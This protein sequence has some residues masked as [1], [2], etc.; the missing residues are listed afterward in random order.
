MNSS[1]QSMTLD[2]NENYEEVKRLLDNI[3]ANLEVLKKY[4]QDTSEQYKTFDLLRYEILSDKN[5][6]RLEKEGQLE[7]VI[8]RLHVFSDLMDSLTSDFV[9][10][11]EKLRE[12]YKDYNST[13]DRISMTKRSARNALEYGPTSVIST[14]LATGMLLAP[15]L[16]LANEGIDW[17]KYCR[18]PPQVITYDITS[19][20]VKSKEIRYDPLYNSTITLYEYTQDDGAG[21]RY[22]NK[23][24]LKDVIINEN[25]DIDKIDLS[26]LKYETKMVN[27]DETIKTDGPYREVIFETVNKDIVGE[28][29]K[30]P[31]L[32]FTLPLALISVFVLAVELF[33]KFVFSEFTYAG[34]D[35]YVDLA[36]LIK[37]KAELF[38]LKKELRE[39]DEEVKKYEKIINTLINRID[40]IVKTS[41]EKITTAEIT[42]EIRKEREVK[43]IDKKFKETKSKNAKEKQ[44]LQQKMVDL[45]ALIRDNISFDDNEGLEELYH[46]VEITDDVLFEKVDDHLK[47]RSVFVPFLKLLDLSKIDFSNVDIR[48]VDFRD[49]NAKMSIPKV[50]NRDASYAKFDNENI[51]DWKDYTGV[52]LIGTEMDEDPKTMINR[53]LA[54]TDENTVLKRSK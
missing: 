31:V 19:E 14:L 12:A 37:L 24:T 6:K 22:R 21:F 15:A 18:R 49:T 5:I 45:I 50:Y 53:Y 44:E 46:S 27:S 20:G 17:Y 1:T 54:I 7:E 42:N 34:V 13:T 28:N 48:Y 2:S 35:I 16:F 8:S 11:K 36:N 25:T 29:E 43:K 30:F 47:I 3:D 23:Y 33:I 4:D 41:S 52:R 10:N 51:Y 9:T 32:T 38:K 26:G 39:D 40:K